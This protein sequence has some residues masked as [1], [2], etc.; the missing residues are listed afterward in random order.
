MDMPEGAQQQAQQALNEIKRLANVK[1]QVQDHANAATAAAKKAISTNPCC[2]FQNSG[3]K[4]DFTCLCCLWRCEFCWYFF[5]KTT[6]APSIAS[7]TSMCSMHPAASAKAYLKADMNNFVGQYNIVKRV[8]DKATDV[9]SA[10]SNA[11]G[12]IEDGADNAQALVD[13]GIP[14]PSIGMVKSM[15]ESLTARF[16]NPA[17]SAALQRLTREVSGEAAIIGALFANPCKE[18]LNDWASNDSFF[19]G[20]SWMKTLQTF[21]TVLGAIT[22]IIN[23]SI[24]VRYAYKSAVSGQGAYFPGSYSN[25]LVSIYAIITH[26]TN[27]QPSH[28]RSLFLVVSRAHTVPIRHRQTHRSN[29]A[30]QQGQQEASWSLRLPLSLDDGRQGRCGN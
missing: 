3:T 29:P 20:C 4:D 18:L 8:K 12:A 19:G 26:L 13:S 1:G 22:A 23:L 15:A 9:Q 16:M 11:R 2:S 28:F 6:I 21:A 10:V 27:H 17:K 25:H 30:A 5:L 24:F 14:K 7:V